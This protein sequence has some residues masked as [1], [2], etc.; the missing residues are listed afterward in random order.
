MCLLYRFKSIHIFVSTP[1]CCNFFVFVASKS[2]NTFSAFVRSHG[3]MQCLPTSKHPLG[4]LSKSEFAWSP[5]R[6]RAKT[7]ARRDARKTRNRNSVT[8]RPAS[9]KVRVHVGIAALVCDLNLF[10]RREL[11]SE[12]SVQP[13]QSMA[14][15]VAIEE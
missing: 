8:V 15:D 10:E 13:S 12:G 6:K 4:C 14:F 3:T 7:R 9:S 1:F 5:S 2:C 11:A